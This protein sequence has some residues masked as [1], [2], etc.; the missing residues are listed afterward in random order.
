[1]S[2]ACTISTPPLKRIAMHLPNAPEHLLGFR[3]HESVP[4]EPRNLFRGLDAEKKGGKALIQHGQEIS[5]FR[6][7]FRLE[8][9]TT[10]IH[11]WQMHKVHGHLSNI[12]FVLFG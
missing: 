10:T 6:L 7:N 4:F 11:Q 5:S 2:I 8:N 9:I 12:V 1:M 3:L